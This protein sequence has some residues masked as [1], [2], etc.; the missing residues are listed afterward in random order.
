MVG[1]RLPT[2]ANHGPI[3]A[4]TASATC[5]FGSV[6]E[7]PSLQQSRV[8]PLPAYFQRWNGEDGVR[9]RDPGVSD[10]DTSTYAADIKGH[11]EPPRCAVRD[12]G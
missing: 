2:D 10:M 6:W 1:R 3:H 9:R 7:C 5:S 11:Q 4:E 12:Y 8:R